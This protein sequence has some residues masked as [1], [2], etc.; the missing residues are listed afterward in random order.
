MA[1]KTTKFYAKLHVH[2]LGQFQLSISRKNCYVK[3]GFQILYTVEQCSSLFSEEKNLKQGA[4]KGQPMIRLPRACRGR[5]AV[6]FLDNSCHIQRYRRKSMSHGFSS[7]ID[8]SLILPKKRILVSYRKF[9]LR[10][11][12][13]RREW[14]SSVSRR[15]ARKN[16]LEL[17]LT[18]FILCH[19]P[20]AAC[21]SN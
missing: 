14:T 11:Q 18:S 16:E 15:F 8:P 20:F 17:T 10:S 13:R 1:Y 19:L 7:F 9:Y 2:N 3:S 5:T 6:R 4:H 21:S 12:L